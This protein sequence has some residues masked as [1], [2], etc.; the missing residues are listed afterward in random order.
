MCPRDAQELPVGENVK[1]TSTSPG[2]PATVSVSCGLRPVV[3]R[4]TLSDGLPF[5]G[6]F[7]IVV[8]FKKLDGSTKGFAEGQNRHHFDTRIIVSLFPGNRCF[9]LD[10]ESFSCR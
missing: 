9:T 4:P 7:V 8:I 5:S 2:S 6:Y 10:D 1:Q 3:L